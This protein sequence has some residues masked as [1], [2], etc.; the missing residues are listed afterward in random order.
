MPDA[1]Y[2]S[3]LTVQSIVLQP[4]ISA[5]LAAMVMAGLKL[6]SSVPPKPARKWFE[7]PMVGVA[8]AALVPV[9]VSFGADPS[10]GAGLGAGVGYIGLVQLESRIDRLIGIGRKG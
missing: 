8:S 9:A 6:L 3:W 10:W 7:V 5:A 1:L 4:T 2:Q